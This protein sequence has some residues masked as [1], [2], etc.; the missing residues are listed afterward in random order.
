MYVYITDAHYIENDI[1]WGL[2]QLYLLVFQVIRI[3]E[4]GIYYLIHKKGKLKQ[5]ILYG[6]KHLPLIKTI[7]I[8]NHL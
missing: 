4:W 6:L 1:V 7:I 3:S 5:T 8:F 2:L